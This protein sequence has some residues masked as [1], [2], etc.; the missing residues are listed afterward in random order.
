MRR[1]DEVVEHLAAGYGAVVAQNGVDESRSILEVAV[2]SEHE[3]DGCAAVENAASES[4]NT[5]HHDD[6]LSDLGW[7]LIAAVDGDV[8]EFGGTLDIAVGTDFH[9]LDDGRVL[10]DTLLPYHPV[11]TAVIVE[12]GLCDL[13][14]PLLEHGVV[15]KLGPH[16][17]VGGNHAV[18]RR[19]RT[20][21]RLVHHLESNPCFLSLTILDDSVAELGVVGGGHLLD[22]EQHTTVADDIV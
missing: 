13:G 15:D 18:E 11:I 19:H 12:S 14:E 20:A 21:T 1:E 16:I 8:L 22:V 7:F 10:D 17:C 9:I 3:L 4:H 5:I 2:V 6:V